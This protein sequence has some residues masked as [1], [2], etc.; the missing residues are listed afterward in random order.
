MPDIEFQENPFRGRRDTA[1]KS[2]CSEFKVSFIIYRSR[3]KPV[4]LVVCGVWIPIIGFEENPSNGNTDKAEKLLCF[5]DK[6]PFILNPLRPDVW[7][8]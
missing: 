8:M 4:I 3:S 1:D 2:V 7:V 6:V 5:E